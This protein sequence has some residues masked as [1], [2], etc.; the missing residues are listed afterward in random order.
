MFEVHYLESLFWKMFCL[1]GVLLIFFIC[2]WGPDTLKGYCLDPQGS[3][4]K[5][6]WGRKNK[7]LLPFRMLI[8]KKQGLLL[9][10]FRYAFEILIL[11]I[12][13]IIVISMCFA[14]RYLELA[15]LNFGT[16]L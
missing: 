2:V 5:I 13:K 8:T 9:L 12:I 10:R 1:E 4:I 15:K 7:I 6:F 11:F 16:I 3:L 14:G